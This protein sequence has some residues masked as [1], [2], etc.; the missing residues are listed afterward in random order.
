MQEPE[1]NF[2]KVLDGFG[3]RH[4]PSSSSLHEKVIKDNSKGTSLMPINPNQMGHCGW[5]GFDMFCE[6][7]DL[8]SGRNSRISSKKSMS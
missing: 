7:S 2:E 6:Y 5:I 8:V 3:N 4:R 1:A